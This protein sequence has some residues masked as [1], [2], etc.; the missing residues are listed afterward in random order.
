MIKSPYH[1]C[2]RVTLDNNSLKD[3]DI[4][5]SMCSLSTSY[6]WFLEKIEKFT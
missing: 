6:K 1:V 5:V 4:S 3:Y 2:I